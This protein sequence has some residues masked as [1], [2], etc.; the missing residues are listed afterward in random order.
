M[1]T[2]AFGFL[3][4]IALSSCNTTI[5]FGRDLRQL[6]TGMENMAHGRSFGDSQANEEVLPTY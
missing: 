6:G 4:A 2:I 5:G 3:A 1:K